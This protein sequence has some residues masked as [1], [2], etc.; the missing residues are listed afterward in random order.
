MAG[1][2]RDVTIDSELSE[3]VFICDNMYVG[4][5]NS[6]TFEPIWLSDHN[7]DRICTIGSP[8]HFTDHN[9]TALEHLHIS[10][11]D[12]D[13]DS[14]RTHWETIFDFIR[15]S[16]DSNVLVYSTSCTSR[17][18]VVAIAYVIKHLN[19]KLSDALMFVCTQ[20]LIISPPT[21]EVQHLL[22]AY[23]AELRLS[24]FLN[25]VISQRLFFEPDPST[26]QERSWQWDR[27]FQQLETTRKTLLAPTLTVSSAVSDR[28]HAASLLQTSQEPALSPVLISKEYPM[29]QYD[30]FLNAHECEVL[31]EYA[32]AQPEIASVPDTWSLDTV[33]RCATQIKIPNDITGAGEDSE[34]VHVLSRLRAKAYSCF[35]IDAT[36]KY[37]SLSQCQISFTPPEPKSIP[38]NSPSIGLHVDQN[39][40]NSSRWATVLVYLNSMTEASGGATVWPCAGEGAHE[41]VVSAGRELLQTGITSTSDAC[42]IQMQDGK[43]DVS[44]VD[45]TDAASRLLSYAVP[46]VL[47]PEQRPSGITRTPCAGTAVCFYSTDNRGTPDPRSWHGKHCHVPPFAS[48][49]VCGHFALSR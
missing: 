14:F 19:M 31:I 46:C 33:H 10:I 47:H 17:S 12:G 15:K 7:I 49:D 39:N 9:S 35:R 25:D 22:Q 42:N 29:W 1:N 2:I 32:K 41:D 34:V 30:G 20:R 13:T 43:V 28:N 5:G 37:A 27:M 3:S 40:G 38:R 45:G 18:A 4:G 16:T 6:P 21:S 24:T 44:M 26:H 23:E 8:R 36:G 11:N 48:C